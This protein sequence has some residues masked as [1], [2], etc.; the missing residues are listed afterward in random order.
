M[1][2][3]CPKC[4]P[5]A[6]RRGS[7]ALRSTLSFTREKLNAI[8]EESHTVDDAGA[9]PILQSNLVRFPVTKINWFDKF[10]AVLLR[11]SDC[12]DSFHSIRLNI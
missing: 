5:D 9:C 8:R 4:Q 2:N 11:R 6:F 10:A 7:S 1:K 12:R 3:G